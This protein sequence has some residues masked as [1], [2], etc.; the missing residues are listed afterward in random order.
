MK[1][2]IVCCDGTWQDLS[3]DYPT[4]VLKITQSIKPIDDR[5]TDQIIYYQEGLG[6]RNKFEQITGGAFGWGI[7]KE[8]QDAYTFLS[9]NYQENDEIYLFG[10]SRGAYT[11]RSLA[12]FIYCSGLLKPN[13]IRHL[14]EAYELYRERGFPPSDP[15]MIE[16]RQNLGEHV[17]IKLLAC[18]DSVGALGIPNIIPIFSEL[19]NA[20]YKFHDTKVNRLIEYALQCCRY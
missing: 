4:N 20:K 6:T 3:T 13:N 19:I 2:L 14:S 11:V 8:I 1:R 12:G 7:D 16:F 9:L 5:D 10:F 18:W 17:P 15:K